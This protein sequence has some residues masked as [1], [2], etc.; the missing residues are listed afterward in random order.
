MIYNTG[1][2]EQHR[3][4]TRTRTRDYNCVRCATCSGFFRHAVKTRKDPQ[5][6]CT[7]LIEGLPIYIHP[8][9]VLFNRAPEWLIYHEFILTT[10]EYCHNVLTIEPKLK[11]S[12]A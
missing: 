4:R 7:T 8:A 5:E 10:R 11:M 12:S 9:S 1:Q 3:T 6:G 2:A